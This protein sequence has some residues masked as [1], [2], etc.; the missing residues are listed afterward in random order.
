MSPPV[1]AGMVER[2]NVSPSVCELCDLQLQGPVLLTS[3]SSVGF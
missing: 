2:G 1:C 3:M